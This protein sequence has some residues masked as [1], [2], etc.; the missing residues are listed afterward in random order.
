MRGR[1]LLWVS[2]AAAGV[3]LGQVLKPE[4]RQRRRALMDHS[5]RRLRLVYVRRV[6]LPLQRHQH[7][8]RQNDQHRQHTYPGD[9]F[10]I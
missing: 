7:D 8:A 6:L 4:A 5:A 3:A 2:A 9:S 10:A 1:L